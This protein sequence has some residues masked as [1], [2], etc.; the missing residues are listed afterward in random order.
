MLRPRSC[1]RHLIAEPFEQAP[2]QQH[3]CVLIVE[4]QDVLA[5]PF[6]GDSARRRTALCAG[7]DREIQVEL[8]SLAGLAVHGDGAVVTLDD[9]V[10]DGE[11]EARA[12]AH[13]LGREERLEDALEHFARHA[14]AAVANR[15]AHVVTFVQVRRVSGDA[16]IDMRIVDLDGD[17]AGDTPDRLRRVDAEV[18]HDLMDLVRSA[19]TVGSPSAIRL[20]ISMSRDRRA[21]QL[22]RF[23]DDVG[24]RRGSCGPAPAAART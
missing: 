14:G 21:Q 4:I 11:A 10:Y 17:R 16:R 2:R 19:S 13:R 20:R 1:S 22:Q 9:A 18:H 23:L 5:A 3:Q 8:R 15:D 24:E 7:D 6:V 12:R